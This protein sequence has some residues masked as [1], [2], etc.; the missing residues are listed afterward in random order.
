MIVKLHFAP[1]NFLIKTLLASEQLLATEPVVAGGFPVALFSALKCI[2]TA[3]DWAQLVDQINKWGFRV[4]STDFGDVD[5]YY[6][7]GNPIWHAE[8]Q[9]LVADTMRNGPYRSNDNE[10]GL[11][12]PRPDYYRRWANSYMK[13]HDGNEVHYQFIKYPQTTIEDCL[14]GFDLKICCIAWHK[15]QIYVHDSF[16]E[17]FD[18]AEIQANAP[19]FNKHSR[20]DIYARM[21]IALRAYKYANRLR[22]ELSSEL[23]SFC[24]TLYTET[25]STDLSVDA[26]LRDAS[27]HPSHNPVPASPAFQGVVKK[28]WRE[29]EAYHNRVDRR[30]EPPTRL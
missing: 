22:F 26:P 29:H 9:W 13:R 18:R 21:F 5:I 27:G 23:N 2:D 17:A 16:E 15:E 3:Q 19:G 24:S 1:F 11:I 7:Q 4:I 20:E 12:R 10:F 6:L 25:K 8:H 14:G 30:T 28:F